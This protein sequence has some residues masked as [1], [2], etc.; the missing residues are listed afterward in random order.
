MAAGLVPLRER[1]QAGLLA[2]GRM[3]VAYSG[4]IDSAYLAWEARQVLGDG[5]LAVIADS[6]S[7]PRRHLAEA[8]EFAAVWGI[9]VRVVRT[10]EM[11]RAEYVR[12]DGARCFHCKDELFNVLEKVSAETGIGV[13]AYGRNV[14]DSGDFRPGQRAAEMHRVVAPLAEAGLGKREIRGLARA[15][16][17]AIWDKPA[18][19]CL[20]SRME[21]G[22]AVT[23]EALRQVEEAEE[24]LNELGFRQVRVRHHGELARVEIER[25]ELARALTV[26]MLGQIS[27]GVKAAGFTFVTLDAEGYRSGSMNALLPVETLLQGGVARAT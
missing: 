18:A 26:E 15:A 14:D 27:A 7:L 22:R 4:G 2:H 17:L 19:A 23:V 21:Y 16:G 9:P 25:G 10:D 3:L 13:V 5:V 20:S 24:W 11:A 1:L 8:L 12:N 6:P